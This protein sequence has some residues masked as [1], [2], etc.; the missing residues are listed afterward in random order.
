MITKEQREAKYQEYCRDPYKVEKYQ[1]PGI[2]CIKINDII[3]YVGKSRNMLQRLADHTLEIEGGR[4]HKTNKYRVLYQAMQKEDCQ[5]SF[6]TLCIITPGYDQE[7]ID[8][9]LAENEA[10]WIDYYK[11]P[12]NH[13]LP[14]VGDPNHRH[15]NKKA[16]TITLEEILCPETELFIF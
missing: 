7:E 4:T 13:Q 6:D 14:I 9:R 16:K 15:T 5:I 10:I 8:K 12:L 3:V 1:K 11:P 2:Y